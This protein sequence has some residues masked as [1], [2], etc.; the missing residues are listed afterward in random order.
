MCDCYCSLGSLRRLTSP[1]ATCELINCTIIAYHG[2]YIGMRVSHR[3]N[4]RNRNL[5][6]D[7][8]ARQHKPCWRIHEERHPQTTPVCPKFCPMVLKRSPGKPFPGILV[9]IFKSRCYCKFR[10][11]FSDNCNI[12]MCERKPPPDSTSNDSDDESVQTRLNDEKKKDKG[13]NEEKNAN[14]EELIPAP[15]PEIEKLV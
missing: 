15:Q 1:S 2:E 3:D 7:P 11:G 10:V 12:C 14:A 5:A 4:S 6:V 13:E 9:V 8:P